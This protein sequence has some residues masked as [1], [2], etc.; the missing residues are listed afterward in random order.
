MASLKVLCAVCLCLVVWLGGI[1]TASA[2]GRH[3]LV[4]GIDAYQNVPSLEKAVNDARA[5]QAALTTAG[6]KVQ[7]VEG[8]D[9]IGFLEA[10]ASFSASIGPGDEAVVYY[11]GHGVE[12]DGRNYLLPSDVPAAGAGQEIVLTN[13]S[14][15]VETLVD[16][17]EARGARI[18]LL[19][20][21][22]CRDN[23]FPK[24]GTRSIGGTRGLAPAPKA[25]GTFILY[26][27]GEGETAL[28]RLTEGDANPNSVFTRA[29]VP[30]IAEPGLPLREVSRR[31]RSDVRQMAMSVNH[32]Q[33]PAVYDQLDGDFSFTAAGAE[34]AAVVTDPCAAARADW[35]LVAT[36]DDPD[37]LEGFVATYP[38]CPV[39]V[40]LARGRLAAL[41]NGT[42][43]GS[44]LNANSGAAEQTAVCDG[45][46]SALAK[47]PARDVPALKAFLKTY[48][49]CGSSTQTAQRFVAKL[50]GEAAERELHLNRREMSHI[51]LALTQF[52]GG[53]ITKSLQVSS[54]EGTFLNYAGRQ[55]LDE[56]A[57]SRGF[58]RDEAETVYLDRKIADVL[59]AMN[60]G[61]QPASPPP[62]TN[63]DFA[64]VWTSSLFDNRCEFQGVAT[65]VSDPLVQ[66]M[67]TFKAWAF[68]DG[69]DSS[70]TWDFASPVPFDL[71]H[72][73]TA[74]VDGQPIGL[75]IS[76]AKTIQPALFNESEGRELNGNITENIAKGKSLVLTGTNELTGEPLSVTY[77]LDG[78]TSAFKRMTRLC[79]RP[80]LMIWV[81]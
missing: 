7:L 24:S 17:L 66:I 56:F 38:A 59:L 36:S 65:A 73:V 4:V 13:R 53:R 16:A 30:L 77:T 39:L 10:I 52:Y 70:I 48:S 35:A 43:V 23:P 44:G 51:A 50:E 31:V 42:E 37:V 62:G 20:L 74:N 29:L 9:Q 12:I 8:P 55:L 41:N 25:E 2:E 11:A 3:A 68:L 47:L 57:R 81:E 46:V 58:V 64:G 1:A 69:K 67:P 19:I 72:P 54:A 28:D 78:F 80:A 63:V 14:I 40:A 22:A 34:V 26:S 18:S 60:V 27:A 76:F 32:A 5:V 71:K 45:A 15:A 75:S 6:F 33:F 61:P 79:K 21:D 49:D